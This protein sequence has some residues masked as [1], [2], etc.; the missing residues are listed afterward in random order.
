MSSQETARIEAILKDYTDHFEFL[1]RMPRSELEGYMNQSDLLFLTAFDNIKG[2]YPVKLFEY[3]ASGIPLVLCP[4][5]HESMEK[6]VHCTNAGFVANTEAECIEILQ[7]CIQKKKENGVIELQRNT[8]VGDQFSRKA[9]TK[10]LAEILAFEL[11]KTPK[12]R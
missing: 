4:S 10:V 3:Y 1:D 5:D 12:R 7:N 6:F 2:W 9:Q 11:K 8:E